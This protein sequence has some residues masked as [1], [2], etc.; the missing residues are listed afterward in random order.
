MEDIMK[1][2]Y[3]IYR[4]KGWWEESCLQDIQSRQQ[5]EFNP[6]L[7]CHYAM[8]TKRKWWIERHS[9]K[10]HRD[11]RPKNGK[12]PHNGGFGKE[13]RDIREDFK[14]LSKNCAQ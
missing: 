7:V 2:K 12:Y 5:K 14:K 9:G 11:K 3:D 6:N 4:Q 1:R 13:A 8:G 10:D